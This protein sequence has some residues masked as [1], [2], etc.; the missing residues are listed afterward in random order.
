VTGF[1]AWP[2]RPRIPV[3]LADFHDPAA[4]Q[5]LA[6]LPPPAGAF[7]RVFTWQPGAG[8]PMHRTPTVVFQVVVSGRLELILAAGP[9]QLGSGDC[10]VQRGTSQAWRVPGA[11][12]CTFAAVFLPAIAPGRPP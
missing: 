1:G 12:P 7:F 9:V 11:E 8:F 4:G 5:K 6:D 3:D 10:L 2:A